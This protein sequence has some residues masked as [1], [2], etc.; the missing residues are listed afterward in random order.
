MNW[1][2]VLA[3]VVPP[4]VVTVTS[5]APVPGGET[6]T[7]DVGE[8]TVKLLAPADP[9]LTAV[10]PMRP[11]PLMVTRVP[12]APPPLLGLTLMSAGAGAPVAKPCEA[13][14]ETAETPFR[15]LTG[16][17]TWLASVLPVPSCPSALAP[18]AMTLPLPSSARLSSLPAD[19]AP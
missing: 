15:P 3:G 6:A 1:S 13:P 9:N 17:G 12:P 5:T 4:G 19:T 8:L 11:V 14:A 16:T 7:I 10:A 18:Q 2:A